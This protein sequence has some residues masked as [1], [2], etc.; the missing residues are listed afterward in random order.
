VNG[1]IDDNYIEWLY[2]G[3]IGAVRNRNPHR[4]FWKLARKLY[5][6]PFT[7]SIRND[8]NRAADG[9]ELRGEFLDAVGADI[10]DESWMALDAS[11]LEVLIGIARRVSFESFGAPAEWFWKFLMNLG[12][13]GYTDAVWSMAIEREVDQIIYN[14]V[15]RQYE[16]DGTGSIFPLR[17]P[18]KDQREL[19]IWAQMSAYILEGDYIHHGPLM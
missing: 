8:E 16:Y 11:V 12:L 2:Q 7:W 1:T 14:F 6:T 10:V 13:N 4:S 15:H 9:I 5:S 19:E 3:D 17:D 18:E